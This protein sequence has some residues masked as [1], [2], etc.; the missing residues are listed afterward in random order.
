[1]RAVAGSAVPIPKNV[2]CVAFINGG[3]YRR[4]IDPKA[5]LAFEAKAPRR[6]YAP[7]GMPT[8][9]PR[10][11]LSRRSQSRSPRMSGPG[12]RGGFVAT[13]Y[14]PSLLCRAPEERI[15]VMSLLG[16]PW[17]PSC[18][19]RSRTRPNPPLITSSALPVS[20]ARAP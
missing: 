9:T 7:E 1:M 16:I 19:L 4:T 5:S 17:S 15:S 12:L 3:R 18:P 2:D 20:R 13:F 6:E 14:P 10:A 11:S 8:G